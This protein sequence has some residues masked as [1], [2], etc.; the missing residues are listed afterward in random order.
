MILLSNQCPVP[1][2]N[3]PRPYLRPCWLSPDYS[4][5]LSRGTESIAAPPRQQRYAADEQ[6][7]PPT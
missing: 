4:A 5:S 7:Y 2:E 6:H 3:P 1:P